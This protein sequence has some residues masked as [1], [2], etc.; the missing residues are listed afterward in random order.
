M[1]LDGCTRRMVGVG[2]RDPTVGPWDDMLEGD[3]RVDVGTS[4]RN[5]VIIRVLHGVIDPRS[6]LAGM[7]HGVAFADDRVG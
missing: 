7:T 5:E 4:P 2:A 3:C 6:L 1:W